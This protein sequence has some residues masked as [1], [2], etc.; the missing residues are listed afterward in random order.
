ME[1]AI[2]LANARRFKV[3]A[4]IALIEQEIAL[5]GAR[6]AAEW[7][8]IERHGNGNG[9]KGLGSN[10]SAQDRA[11]LYHLE[12]DEECEHYRSVRDNLIN[13]KANLLRASVELEVWR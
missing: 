11:M 2:R 8:I 3:D 12:T 4:E 7:C 10:E 13:A 1:F 9:V 5:A 6:V